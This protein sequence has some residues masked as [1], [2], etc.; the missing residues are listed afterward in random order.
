MP[1]QLPPRQLPS[2]QRGLGR[3]SVGAYRHSVLY[4][5]KIHI[6]QQYR[7][8]PKMRMLFLAGLFQC[9]NFFGRGGLL[10]VNQEL[11]AL[12][13]GP[14]SRSKNGR[15]T[16]SPKI[17]SKYQR[18]P[19]SPSAVR[20]DDCFKLVFKHLPALHS[21]DQTK[22]G[23]VNNWPSWCRAYSE[24]HLGMKYCDDACFTGASAFFAFTARFLPGALGSPFRGEF[25]LPPAQVHLA[26][27]WAPQGHRA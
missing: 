5:M 8:L 22:V 1:D 14:F 16:Y 20:F 12:I 27:P 2:R 19:T 10:A 24:G 9:L 7:L 3:Q 17:H 15:T 21:R 13:D 18:G 26:A 6:L 11:Q 25:S 23:L 4:G